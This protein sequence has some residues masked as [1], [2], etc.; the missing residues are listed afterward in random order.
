MLH[1]LQP[2]LRCLLG[3]FIVLRRR[4]VG[5]LLLVIRGRRRLLDLLLD[6]LDGMERTFKFD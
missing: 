1:L 3:F 2:L 5:L 4:R 6:G